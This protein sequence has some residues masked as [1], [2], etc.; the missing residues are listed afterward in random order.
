[1]IL[2]KSTQSTFFCALPKDTTSKENLAPMRKKL[3]QVSK[4]LAQ[5]SKKFAQ[6]NKKLAQESQNYHQ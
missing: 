3:P 1:M 5:A 4:K 6:G 2:V